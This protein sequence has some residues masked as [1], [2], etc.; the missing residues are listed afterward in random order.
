M[1]TIKI[2]TK[3]RHPGFE[4]IGTVVEILDDE[5][6]V[7]FGDG[8]EFCEAIENFEIIEADDS[9]N[10]STEFDEAAELEN[11]GESTTVDTIRIPKD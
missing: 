9:D 10:E 6:S 4:C 8:C 5:I 7:D 11:D 1:T 2:G 3:I